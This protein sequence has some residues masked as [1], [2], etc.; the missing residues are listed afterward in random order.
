MNLHYREYG[1]GP[2]LLILHGFL[3]ASGNWHTLSRNVFA[4]HFRVIAVD[5]RN[6]GDSPHSDVFDYETLADDILRFMDTHEV[7]RAH[8]LGH[9]M[10]G[11]TAMHVAI[12]YPERVDRLIVADIA[13]RAY[14]DRHNEILD[15][16]WE[17]EPEEYSDRESIDAALSQYIRFDDVRM[18]LMKNL[19]LDKSS[20]R[21][22]WKM[23]LE[24]LRENYPLLNEALPD[25]A[26]FDGPTL[27]I[28]GDLSD[29]ITDDDRTSIRRHFPASR[30]VT[31]NDAGHWLHADQPDAFGQTV[32]AFLTAT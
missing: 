30:I 17:V 10:G 1:E 3:G 13:P 26:H 27:F 29:Y 31:I 11:K 21:Y 28:R 4:E 15:A 14:D 20:R 8:L 2:P 9:S 22:S 6:H 19:A 23:N 24:T 12:R 5:Q 7:D 16:L 25:G 18:F 32:N